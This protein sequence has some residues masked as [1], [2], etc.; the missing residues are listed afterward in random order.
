MYAHK[1][2][3]LIEALTKQV[4]RGLAYGHYRQ[5]FGYHSS[6]VRLGVESVGCKGFPKG[7]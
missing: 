3:T 4:K 6:T 7:F 1:R 2:F 5:S